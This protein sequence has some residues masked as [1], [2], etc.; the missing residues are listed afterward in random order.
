MKRLHQIIL[1]WLLLMIVSQSAAAM[2]ISPV[3][4]D[5]YDVHV[6]DQ[7]T[8][9]LINTDEDWQKV[10]LDLGL[11][12]LRE[13]GTVELDDT[14]TARQQAKH[15][16]NINESNYVLQP[17]KQQIV[18]I[19]IQNQDFSAASLVLFVK[20]HGE[21]LSS[22]MAV[23]LLFSTTGPDQYIQ[24]SEIN[25]SN[26]HLTLTLTNPNP[27]HVFFGGNMELRRSNGSRE[28]ISMSPV[29]ILANTQRTIQ[30]PVASDTEQITL[31]STFL[32]E[33]VSWP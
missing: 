24:V 31:Y 23:L 12:T 7:F 5:A 16:V 14:Y 2:I 27:C 32:A 18:T 17:G 33:Q 9:T 11:F 21:Q 15:Y 26:V 22:R 13:D 6:G 29:L 4:I 25:L 19:E 8:L 28:V 3:I 20:K 30:L 1:F 10:S